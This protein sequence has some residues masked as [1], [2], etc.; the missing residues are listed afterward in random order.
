MSTDVDT[1]KQQ[2][3]ELQ[4]QLAFQEEALSSLD[5]ALAAQQQDILFLR[6]QLEL[7]RQHQLEQAVH[8]EIT[9]AGT[10]VDDPP[11]HY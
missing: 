6:R 7:M 4:S 8:S 10:P 11:P 2:M 5:G 3:M 1:L 9:P